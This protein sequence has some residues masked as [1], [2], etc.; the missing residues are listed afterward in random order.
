MKTKIIDT[1]EKY[2]SGKWI[3]LIKELNALPDGK[4]ISISPENQ[5]IHTIQILVFQ[6]AR[7]LNFPVYT[8]VVNGEVVISRKVAR[9]K[10]E[11]AP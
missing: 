9:E 1:P 4:S 7:I 5:N 6:A 10:S 3:N 8:R 2:H 11:K